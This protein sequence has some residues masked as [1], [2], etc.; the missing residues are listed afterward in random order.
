MCRQHG[1]NFLLHKILFRCRF[2]FMYVKKMRERENHKRKWETESET[3]SIWLLILT[4]LFISHLL[5]ARF[6][7]GKIFIRFGHRKR[8]SP[9]V[10][11]LRNYQ[12]INRN[13]YHRQLA[14]V[15]IAR[16]E[17]IDSVRRSRCLIVG[18][19]SHFKKNTA[20]V[21]HK[22]WH[23]NKILCVFEIYTI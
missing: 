5:L 4:H 18:V 9:L 10:F 23:W 13:I 3:S 1:L 16:E 20:K 19:K 11:L 6:S 7:R 15:P 14:T 12:I 2:T 22:S 8:I 21:K 17:N